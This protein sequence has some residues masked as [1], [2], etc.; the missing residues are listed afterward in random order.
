MQVLKCDSFRLVT[1]GGGKI[2]VTVLEVSRATWHKR[3]PLRRVRSFV[4]PG[5]NF[6]L[7]ITPLSSQ[8][9]RIHHSS[10]F[11]APCPPNLPALARQGLPHKN[12]P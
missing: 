6:G 5:E 10:R 8:L 11:C 9:A 12:K 1:K 4:S 3:L 2:H 7:G